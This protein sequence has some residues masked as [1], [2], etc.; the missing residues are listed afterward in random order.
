[1]SAPRVLHVGLESPATR[2]GGLNVYLQRLVRAERDAGID[3]SIVW[4]SDDQPDGDEHIAPGLSWPRR[5]VAFARTIRRSRAEVVDVHFAAHA[6]GALLTGALR[7]RP[8]VVHF[9]GPWALESQAAGERGLGVWVKGRVEGFVLRRA[10]RVIVL[11]NAFRR[12]AIQQYR[13]VPHRV[14][15]VPPGVD[16]ANLV[17]RRRVRAELGIRDNEEMWLS[18]RRLVPRM[19]L[20][21]GLRAFALGGVE[22]RRY[23]IVGDGPLRS[24]LETVARDLGVA[25]A[26]TFVGRVDDDTLG[27]WYDAADVSLVPSVAHEGF[28]L[29]VGE[30]LAHGTPVVASDRDGLRDAAR[31]SRAVVLVEPDPARMARAAADVLSKPTCVMMRGSPLP[32]TGGRWSSSDTG[33]SI[34]RCATE[35]FLEES[36]FW[37]T[38]HASAGASSRSLDWWARSTTAGGLT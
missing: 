30:S 24:E 32:R 27:A 25:S 9:Q 35:L 12:V 10:D 11:S 37:I 17:D 20:D 26:V 7:G 22:N 8:M 29:V 31:L 28:G 34:R 15:V 36:W 4:I 21:V 3:A 33:S 16:S 5:F 18:V 2:H 19:G 14:V 13:V 1:M 23:V 6:F 38:L